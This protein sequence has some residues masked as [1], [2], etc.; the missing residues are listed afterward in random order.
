MARPK[1]STKTPSYRLHRASG[2]AIVTIAGHDHYLGEFESEK[3]RDRYDQLI[4]EWLRNGRPVSDTRG[5]AVVGHKI[6]VRE[7]L[8][9]YLQNM[10]AD[11]VSQR[12]YRAAFRLLNRMYGET[13]AENFGPLALK[14]LR[15]QLA[16]MRATRW[17]W[18]SQK[19]TQLPTTL[20]RRTI[21]LYIN[22]ILLLFRWGVENERISANVSHA[23][24]RVAPLKPGAKGVRSDVII[25][26]APDEDVDAVMAI[27]SPEI[28][29]MISLQR[30]TGMR[31]GELVQMRTCDIDRS[32]A[33]WKYSPLHHKTERYGKTRTIHF[34]PRAQ[35]II[36][37]FLRLD[38]HAYIFS[39]RDALANRYARLRET[40]KESQQSLEWRRVWKARQRRSAGIGPRAVH[41]HY[42]VSSY[43]CAIRSLC[44]K[45]D[46]LR[47]ANGTYRGPCEWH[48]H[49]L[50]HSAATDVA[51]QFG[52]DA[53]RAL[54][55]HS[56]VRTTRI[57]VKQD[58]YTKRDDA[59]SA[60][61]MSEV[62]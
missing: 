8:A 56:D 59:L 10:N 5:A 21:N 25:E 45:V 29:A 32:A 14:S 35:K 17:C 13:P 54:L 26:P 1:G 53:T 3:S 40:S 20:A 27:A 31:A 19:F 43:G 61:V 41:D 50:R 23:L 11:G 22:G 9:I 58:V 33:V 37:P 7:L 47:K 4:A 2:R 44:L 52:E 18:R 12:Q 62:G 16:R 6:A 48:S 49:R 51:E 24:D 57:Y 55:G 46:R 15:D 42:S 39:P 60:N 38:L 36:E 34:G 28:A 30:L